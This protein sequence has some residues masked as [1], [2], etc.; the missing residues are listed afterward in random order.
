VATDI[1]NISTNNVLGTT[2]SRDGNNNPALRTHTDLVAAGPDINGDRSG[3]V[4]F[5]EVAKALS[6]Y[7]INNAVDAFE[8][9]ARGIAAATATY[10]LSWKGFPAVEEVVE[11]PD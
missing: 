5:L 11:W 7:K 10:L 6:Q 9:H 1:R 4:G 2:N 3:T 8:M